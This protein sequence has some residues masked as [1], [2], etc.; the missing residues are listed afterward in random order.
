MDR[1]QN[2]D[3]APLLQHPGYLT[4]VQTGSLEGVEQPRRPP[5]QH[6]TDSASTPDDAFG[7]AAH[8][9]HVR[10]IRATERP[11]TDEQKVALRKVFLEQLLERE[12]KRKAARTG[13]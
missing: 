9:E 5:G 10:K 2:S 11:V 6:D 12:A 8:D 1:C 3:Q 7:S 4:T 13:A